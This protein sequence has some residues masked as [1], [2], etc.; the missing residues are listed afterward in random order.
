MLIR[1]YQTVHRDKIQLFA[2]IIACESKQPLEKI[3]KALEDFFA[4]SSE[5]EVTVGYIVE[6]DVPF[7]KEELE[8]Q[9]ERLRYY[10]FRVSDNPHLDLMQYNRECWHTH[11]KEGK[12]CK[13]K[14]KQPFWHRI[15]SFCV[16]K[17][18]HRGINLVNFAFSLQN[19]WYF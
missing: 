9:L 2:E 3:T 15:R 8:A 11:H 16:R 4:E 12:P 1:K 10:D 7:S 6:L 5:N 18:Y 13:A 17:R 14:I 19:L